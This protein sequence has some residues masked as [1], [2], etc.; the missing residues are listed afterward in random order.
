MKLK[1]ED[2]GEFR[3]VKCGTAAEPS[4]KY[5]K[6]E[7]HGERLNMACVRCG[8]KWSEPTKDREMVVVGV[9]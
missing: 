1:V 7:V 8:Y 9:K 6:D 5:A 4:I 2:G 3:C